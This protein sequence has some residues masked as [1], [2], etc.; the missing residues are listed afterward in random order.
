MIHIGTNP[1]HINDFKSILFAREDFDIS[2]IALNRVKASFQFLESF[3]K[4]KLIYGI[5]TGFG[6]MAPYRISEAD[7][8]KL[9][10]NLIRSHSSGSGSVLPPLYIKAIILARTNTILQGYSGLDPDVPLLFKEMI[11][12]EMLPLIFEHGGVGASGDLV[13]LAHLAL[14][15]IGEGEMWY[16]NEI[17]PASEVFKNE[18]LNPISISIREGLGVMNGTAAMS[19]IGIVNLIYAQTLLDHS[20]LASAWLNELVCSYNDHY[21]FELNDAKKHKGQHVVAE[22]MRNLLEDSGRTRDRSAHLYGQVPTDE[23]LNDK[24]QEFYSIRCVPQILGPIFDT[25]QNAEEVL[26]AEVNSANDNPIVDIASAN[27]YHGGNFHGDYVAFE[28]D[29]VRI[30]IAKLTMLIE[31]QLNYLMNHKL[32]NLLPPFAN[33]GK[34]GLNFGLQGIQF[35]AVS[36]TAE[37]QTLSNP[38]YIHSIPNNNDNQ[39]IVS[40]GS[41]SAWLTKKS[42]D[43]S[44]EVLAIQCMALAQATDILECKGELSAASRELHEKIRQI[45]PPIIEDLPQYNQIKNI[46][47]LLKTIV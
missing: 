45:M 46:T 3:S 6:P 22:K 21:S 43:N 29:K 47:Q 7:R 11:S 30:A 14:G 31:R 5:N 10:I 42:I 41:N 27:V 32:N 35:T 18:N 26:T 28:M 4:N 19:G 15:M 34:L 44:F 39:D 9:Q 16:K 25:L 23:I 1:I 12:R 17:K 38:M 40:M 2:D 8:E 36:T 37:N 33:M 13:Q 24:V 20:I